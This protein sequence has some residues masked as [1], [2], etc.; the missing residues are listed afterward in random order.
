LFSFQYEIIVGVAMLD[1]ILILPKAASASVAP[2]A[3]V[4]TVTDH[5][6][7]AAGG[8][9]AAGKASA[10]DVTAISSLSCEAEVGSPQSSSRRG[11]AAAVGG[12]VWAIGS[13]LDS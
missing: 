1:G 6:R 10:S 4:G 13:L 8:A 2:M 7:I 12:V 5:S 11:I 9:V 3:A